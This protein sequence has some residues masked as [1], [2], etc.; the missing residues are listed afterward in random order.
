M[1]KFLYQA[2]YTAEGLRGLQKDTAA[3]REAAAKVAVK[4]VGGKLEEFYFCFGKTDVICLLDMPDN[5]SAAAMSSTISATGLVNGT[6]TPLL[7]VKEMDK[8]LEKKT[9]YRGP[10]VK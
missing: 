7:T 4:S 9:N 10:G 5:A 8:G 3:R 2:T 6:L 1:P